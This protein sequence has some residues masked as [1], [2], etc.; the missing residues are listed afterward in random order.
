MPKSEL[1]QAQQEITSRM[2]WI[3]WLRSFNC[4]GCILVG[5]AAAVMPVVAVVEADEV[6]VRSSGVGTSSWELLLISIWKACM[7]SL[8][9]LARRLSLSHNHWN[10]LYRRMWFLGPRMES[11]GDGPR[12]MSTRGG[13]IT[14]QMWSKFLF[15]LEVYGT[16]DDKLENLQTLYRSSCLN[17][18]SADKESHFGNK[19]NC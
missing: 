18:A 13:V 3:T 17:I 6:T 2:D 19:H 11:R 8:H 10:V 12:S 5:E 4:D 1:K 16:E 15:Y 9:P 7:S 14:I